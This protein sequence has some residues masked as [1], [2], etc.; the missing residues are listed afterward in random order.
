M[1]MEKL[2]VSVIKSVYRELIY[3]YL[4]LDSLQSHMSLCLLLVQLH[5]IWC[6]EGQHARYA[7]CDHLSYAHSPQLYM[8]SVS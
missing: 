6:L 4:S 7:L 5:V 2:E 8:F 3:N 1:I